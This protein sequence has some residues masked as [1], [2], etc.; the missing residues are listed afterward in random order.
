MTQPHQYFGADR[1]RHQISHEELRRQLIAADEERYGL[2]RELSGRWTVRRRRVTIGV[3]A[4]FV[5]AITTAAYWENCP[6]FARSDARSALCLQTSVAPEPLASAPLALAPLVPG[7]VAPAP[8]VSMSTVPA[9]VP[10][11]L[12]QSA[13]AS[14]TDPNLALQ[15]H[16]L[17]RMSSVRLRQT[18]SK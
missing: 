11:E 5:G 13:E 1:R 6:P 4:A 3:G 12:E 15:R 7:P 9:F 8:L 14:Q 17:T 18:V 10:A 2:H 16:R